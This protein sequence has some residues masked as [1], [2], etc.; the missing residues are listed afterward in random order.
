MQSFIAFA[1]I[2]YAFAHGAYANPLWKLQSNTALYANGLWR[3]LI[4]LPAW[5]AA[6]L[7]L[8]ADYKG[9]LT[10][11]SVTIAFM[12]I[13]VLRMSRDGV[14]NLRTVL[15][16]LW[17]SMGAYA[18]IV[19]N[20][21]IFG[22]PVC[23]WSSRAAEVGWET[24]AQEFMTRTRDTSPGPSFSEIFSSNSGQSTE[25]TSYA[26]PEVEVYKEQAD[27]SKKKM[28]TNSDNS[29]Y[30]DPDEEEWKKINK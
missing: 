13:P 15:L 6:I 24:T 16:L 26:Q 8:L 2:V 20:L 10:A 3:A 21:S 19:L 14:A 18:R 1:L 7:F 28:R 30:W 17:A 29:M 25:E 12:I 9:T 5:I 11:L 22:I 4:G 23:R 27:G